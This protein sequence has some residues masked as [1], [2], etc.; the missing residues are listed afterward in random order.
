MQ[1]P[2][3]TLF[4]NRRKLL[5]HSWCLTVTLLRRQPG[6]AAGAYGNSWPDVDYPF[7]AG[8]GLQRPLQRARRR[9]WVRRRRC[10]P[11]TSHASST[12]ADGAVRKVLGLVEPGGAL[13]LPLGWGVEGCELQ[14]RPVLEDPRVMQ[15][16]EGEGSQDDEDG[17]EQQG[18]GGGGGSG[19]HV[20]APLLLG[21][22]GEVLHMWSAGTSGAAGSGLAAVDLSMVEDGATRLLSCACPQDAAQAVLQRPPSNA[23]QQ[24]AQ[25]HQQG[26]D[27]GGGGEASARLSQLLQPFWLSVSME[28]DPLVMAQVRL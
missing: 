14:V 7:K 20:P 4:I 15:P 17:M 8:C 26:G 16:N 9:R 24:Q 25:R 5:P 23:Q 3:H 2:T 10:I 11:P 21:P 28:S 18:R 12:Q 19:D 27:G 13:P 22:E 6:H 1:P